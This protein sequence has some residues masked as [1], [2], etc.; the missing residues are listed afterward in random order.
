MYLQLSIQREMYLQ[1]RVPMTMTIG[2]ESDWTQT[3]QTQ[4]VMYLI[5]E[6]FVYFPPFLFLNF[7]SLTHF[8]SALENY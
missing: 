4:H 3:E 6:S 5:F 1:V 7:I 2:Q 8:I